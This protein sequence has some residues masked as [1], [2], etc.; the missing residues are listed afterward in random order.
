M[1]SPTLLS[2]KQH[3]NMKRIVVFTLFAIAASAGCHAQTYLE[4][5]R[6]DVPGQ[7]HLTITQSKEIDDL[8][9][10]T[11]AAEPAKPKAETEKTAAKTETKPAISTLKE[12]ETTKRT[13]ETRP[14]DPV[15][16]ETDEANTTVDTSRKLMRGSYKITG[17]RVQAFSGG[18]SREA[19][20]KAREIGDA[21]KR[22]FPSQPVYVHFYSPRWTCR[23]GNYRTYEE[24]S[25]VLREIKAMGYT[26]ASIVKGKITV[27]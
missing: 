24:A 1:H 19:K 17:Y 21:I 9:N 15:A 20:N 10:G 11:P 8:V 2:K 12:A 22:R 25:Q 5:L 26:E 16:T 18:N 3:K 14:A 13:V 7:G 6:K 27:Q 23:I 4:T